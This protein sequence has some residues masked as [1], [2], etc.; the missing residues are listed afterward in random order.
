MSDRLAQHGGHDAIGS[1]LDQLEAEASPDAVAHVEE[2]LRAEVIHQ[3]KLVVREG[4]PGVAGGN[5]PRGL[6]AVRVALIH[7]DAAEVILERFHRVEYR[8]GPVAHAGVQAADG[9][10]E[11]W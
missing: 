5:R 10:G 2:L 3:P 8:G 6:A 1:P 4:A 7:R 9:S 11:K